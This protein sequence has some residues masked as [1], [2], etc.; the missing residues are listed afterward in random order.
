MDATTVDIAA[1]TTLALSGATGVT[2]LASGGD[3]S[4]STNGANDVDICG[5]A[6][7]ITA[8]DTVV[9]SIHNCNYRSTPSSN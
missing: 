1:T 5:N 8:G 3:V 4:I 2:M 7:S 6:L 9:S